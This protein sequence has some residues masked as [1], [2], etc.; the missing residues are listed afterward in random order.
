MDK[1]IGSTTCISNQNDF[2]TL[3]GFVSVGIN[4]QFLEKIRKLSYSENSCAVTLTGCVT[5][6]MHV[7][8]EF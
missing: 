7:G 2:E 3:I 4:G 5:S 8:E 6:Y 1:H